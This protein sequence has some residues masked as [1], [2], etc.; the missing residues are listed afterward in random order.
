M[1][2][3]DRQLVEHV[4]NV[5]LILFQQPDVSRGI[6]EFGHQRP[7]DTDAAVKSDLILAE[8]LGENLVILQ[9]LSDLLKLQTS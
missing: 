6:G 7:L 8:P 9:I 1:P 5:D 2:P 3:I 4:G